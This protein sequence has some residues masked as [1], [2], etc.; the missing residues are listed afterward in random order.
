MK[1]IVEYLELACEKH[2]NK[3]AYGDLDGEITFG[4][5]A[6]KSKMIATAISKMNLFKKPI[7]LY[8]EKNTRLVEARMASTYSGNFYVC[9]DTTM[10]EDRVAS[11]FDT[12]EP[13]LI[14]T[15]DE[16]YD[17]VSYKDV[18]KKKYSDLLVD[19]DEELLKNV[20]DK[21]ID[22]DICYSI[23]T[24][25]STG[26]PKGTVVNHNSLLK[27]LEWF[28]NTMGI[29][30]N[31]I[32]GGQTQFYFSASLSDF[33][34][35]IVK[36]ATYYMVPK[37]YF[38]FPMK[39]IELL[40]EKRINTIYWVP[41]A[42]ALLANLDVFKYAKPLYLKKIMFAGE[43]MHVKH[44]NYLIKYLPDCTY[45]NLFGPTETVDICSYYT[46]ERE[47][48]VDESLPIGKHCN[49]CDTF[50]LKDDNTLAKPGEKGEL[51]VRGSFLAQGYYNMPEK[52]KEAFCEN[53]LQK[54]YPERIYRT[55]DLV[56]ENERGEYIYLSRKDFQIK[57]MG[58]RIELGEIESSVTSLDN[59]KSC[60]ALYDSEKDE[61][62]LIYE[63]KVKLDEIY[64]RVNQKLPRYMIPSKIIKVPQMALNPNGKIDRA[65]YKKNYKNL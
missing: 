21:I 61:I 20:Y 28:S 1:T 25:G 65:Y 29:D 10:P 38:M 64:E 31:T 17:K 53:P 60:V 51:C 26:K 30:E 32:F 46:V 5:L 39:I 3:V 41:S 58:Y 59:I 34:S 12:L 18:I 57:H 44:L 24:S 6:N 49:N 56:L 27:Y 63:G 43:V 8:F 7:V 14:I 16:L 45:T 2:K 48:K 62:I 23:F 15:D 19:I 37:S 11:I 36:G 4:Q 35:T 55:G 50:I 22:T 54:A 42:L 13:A 9:M 33:Y 47:F 52:T 40:N